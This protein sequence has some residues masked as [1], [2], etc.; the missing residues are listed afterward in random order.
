MVLGMGTAI[1]NTKKK[2][3]C[4]FWP[5][6]ASVLFWFFIFFSWF[7]FGSHKIKERII[8]QARVFV[9]GTV[10]LRSYVNTGDCWLIHNNVWAVGLCIIRLYC[11]HKSAVK[12]PFVTFAWQL[13]I[14][15]AAFRDF[16]VFSSPV[17]QK[18]QTIKDAQSCTG[19][20]IKLISW[21]N[22]QARRTMRNVLRP[23]ALKLLTSLGVN[24]LWV[25]M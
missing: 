13:R 1:K 2:Q 6:G 12:A 9:S 22:D 5:F 4:L 17:S 8:I 15:S 24:H 21:I 16:Q 18:R 25:R 19:C 7:L 14:R 10:S 23:V 3:N 11:G 20:N